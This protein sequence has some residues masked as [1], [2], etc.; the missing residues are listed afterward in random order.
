MHCIHNM[1]YLTESGSPVYNNA[2][3]L[4]L[5]YSYVAQGQLEIVAGG[6]V[7]PDEA[8]THY[9]A[10]IDQLVTGHEWLRTHL[11]LRPK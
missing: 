1:R 3:F 7:M 11:Y 5:A 2:L 9:W 10:L 4:I 8:V 6:W